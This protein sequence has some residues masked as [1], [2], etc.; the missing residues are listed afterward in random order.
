MSRNRIALSAALLGVFILGLVAGRMI[1]FRQMVPPMADLVSLANGCVTG[2]EAYVQYRYGSYTVAKAALLG[3]VDRLKNEDGALTGQRGAQFELGLTYG[4]LALNAE[5]A[6]HLDE[7]V[8][9]M[10]LA[11]EALTPVDK[12]TTEKLVRESVEHLDR[13]WDGRMAGLERSGEIA[14]NQPGATNRDQTVAPET[15]RTPAAAGS[16][17]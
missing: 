1:T 14:S 8:T 15:S 13:A 10:R 5:R 2:N 3:N 12:N 6:G 9:Y 7:G 4:R 11:V 17:R 16:G